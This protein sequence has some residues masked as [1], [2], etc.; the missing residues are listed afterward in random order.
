MTAIAPAL[1]RPSR[2]AVLALPLAALLPARAVAAPAPAPAIVHAMPATPAV[3]LAR[4]V[5]A[6]DGAGFGFEVYRSV[7][8]V[9]AGLVAGEVDLVA[10]PTYSA[11][12]LANRGAGISLVNVLTWGLLYGLA[13]DASLTRIEDLAGKTV[14]VAARHDAP[15]L[16]LRLALT[17]AGLDPERDLTLAYSATSAEI[18]PQFLA[19]RGDVAILPEPAASTA[20]IRA[21]QAGQPLH[22][23][24][25]ITE[26][27]ARQTGAPPRLPQ[28]G[29]CV[30]RRFLDAR[31]EAVALLAAACR[32]AG[33]WVAAD[34]AAAAELGAAKLGL[35]AAIVAASLPQFRLDVVDAGP[36]RPDLERYFRDLM[37]LSP[38]IVGGRLP[39]PAFYWAP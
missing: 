39:D 19:G 36:A 33:R 26:I 35:P 18:V 21:K 34:P 4:A 24:L 37:T 28:A 25:D 9:R 15:D 22:R 11:A 3:V 14:L 30:S 2:R 20:L 16:I 32:D 31:P 29:L 27:R 6:L 12:N 8:Q 7:D 10:L 23:A 5:A 17:A 38:D 13:R 1:L